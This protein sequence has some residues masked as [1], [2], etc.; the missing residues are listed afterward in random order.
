MQKIIVILAAGLGTRMGGNIPKAQV[1]IA[2]KPMICHVLDRAIALNAD[3]IIITLGDDMDHLRDL[4]RNYCPNAKFA[5]QKERLGTGH[6][7]GI[8][9]EAIEN[10][11][12]M[13]SLLV[14]YGD[15][16]FLPLSL[17][18][19]MQ[20]ALLDQAS[21]LVVAGFHA[22][23]PTGYGRLV[24]DEA[25]GLKAIIEHKEADDDT[26]Q[27]TLCNS[28]VM[29]FQTKYVRDWAQKIRNDNQK[30]EYYL[31]D[32]AAIARA[33]GHKL[34]VATADHALLQG[35]DT[36]H[37]LII[38]QEFWQQQMRESLI[39]K[40]VKMVAP[41]TVFLHHDTVVEAGATLEPYVICGE[42]VTIKAGANIRAFSH[43][44]GATIG[45]NAQI[46]PYARLRPGAEIGESAR[47]GN[48][49]EVKKAV[50]EQGAKVNHLSYIGDAIIGA[51]ANIG[52]GT[53]TCN[54]DGV[55]KHKTKIGA[56]AFIG[57]NSALVAPVEIGAGAIVGAGSTITKTVSDHALAI[58]RTP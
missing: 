48:F 21:D 24:L 36:P 25:G 4:A 18:E 39:A 31:T 26:R 57:S 55:N 10:P 17:L 30:R 44:E 38:A 37:A 22:S 43:L 53:I 45:E 49:V 29:G 28:G 16:P 14:L 50:L 35:V 23:D 58:S 13:G 47:I 6:A 34:S 12:Q 7:L 19:A 51:A 52:A 40:G 42:A 20:G 41:H 5:I 9:L 3:Q 2:G 11:D 56:G 27:I 54:Y 8:A 32:T 15:S 33:A 1:E 46:G